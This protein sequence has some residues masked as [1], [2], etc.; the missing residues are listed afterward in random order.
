[1]H[2]LQAHLRSQPF[3]QLAVF[4]GEL[5]NLVCYAIDVLLESDL[6]Y[7]EHLGAGGVAL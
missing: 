6:I 1:M 2:E 5:N 4:R 7:L 3:G